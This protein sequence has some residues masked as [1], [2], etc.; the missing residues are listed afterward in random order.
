M[1]PISLDHLLDLLVLFPWSYHQSPHQSLSGREIQNFK[2]QNSGLQRAFCTNS[3]KLPFR[4]II[5]NDKY[6]K[7]IVFIFSRIVSL[8]LYSILTPPCRANISLL[9]MPKKSL[10]AFNYIFNDNCL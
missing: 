9:Y 5:E 10:F 6:K 8:S 3:S 1:L 4:C 2:N 7:I